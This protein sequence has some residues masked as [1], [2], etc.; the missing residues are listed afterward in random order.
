MN[1]K[2]SDS[3][4]T[5]MERGVKPL[6]EL[7]AAKRVNRRLFGV[8]SKIQANDPLQNNIDEFEWKALL[9]ASRRT[10]M[11]SLHLT[12]NSAEEC[13]PIRTYSRSTSFEL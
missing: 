7:V 12:V 9:P 4:T 6:S 1:S 5:K 3:S 13:R 11:Q 10:L 8:G 2:R